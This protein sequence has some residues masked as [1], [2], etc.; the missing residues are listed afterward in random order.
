MVATIIH[1]ATHQL[2]ANTGLMPRKV[3]RPTWA[4]E[5]LATYFESAEIPWRPAVEST[6][7]LQALA[8]V[9]SGEFRFQK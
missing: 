1:E 9:E 6:S 3:R 8:L 7:F 5:G 4:A 2:A